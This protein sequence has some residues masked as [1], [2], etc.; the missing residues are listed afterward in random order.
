VK[1][2]FILGLLV[3]MALACG[4]AKNTD[5]IARRVEVADDQ[6]YDPTKD[7]PDRVVLKKIP[8]PPDGT[9]IQIFDR[10]TGTFDRIDDKGAWSVGK[11]EEGNTSSHPKQVVP[12]GMPKRNRMT[13]DG[14]ARLV[15][16]IND[17]DFVHQDAKQPNSGPE[18]PRHPLAFTVLHD[19][20]A[21]SVEL[22]GSLDEPETLGHFQPLWMVLG[23]EAWSTGRVE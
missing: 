13:E 7:T 2:G 1:R 16:A 12:K 6:K 4:G 18:V 17:A 22:D 15:Q 20:S 10:S 23:E 21:V 5:G 8:V 14:L 9:L 3:A 11:L 19:G